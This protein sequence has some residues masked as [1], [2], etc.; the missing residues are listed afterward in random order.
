MKLLLVEDDTFLVKALKQ[1]LS[2][3]YQVDAAHSQT[4][5]QTQ[6]NLVSYQALLVDEKL[7]QGSGLEVIRTARTKNA[8]VPIIVITSQASKEFAIQC[9][10]LGVNRFLEKPFGLEELRG[11]LA[12]LTHQ[13]K[14]L[15]ISDGWCYR[16][17]RKRIEFEGQDAKLTPIE[18]AI[19]EYLIENRG[20]C[21]PRDELVQK[22]WRDANVSENTL[23]THLSSLRKKAKPVGDRIRVSRGRGYFWE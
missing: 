9:L 21:V 16:R 13:I 15:E 12:S 19:V 10:N 3:E 5:A 14:E 8:S 18:F 2:D 7:S 23:D 4:D 17:D 6:L 22:I 20:R 11:E 1:T